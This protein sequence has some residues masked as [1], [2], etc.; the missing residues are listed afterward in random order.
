GI[1]VDA[2]AAFYRR[3]QQLPSMT[4]LH[5]VS[6]FYAW[7]GAHPGFNGYDVAG[8]WM[9]F[10]LD[11]QGAKKVR[12]YSRGVAAKEAFGKSVEDLEKLWHARL[13]AFVLRP[14]TELLLRQRAGE[15]V[16]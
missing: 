8:S 9:R 1:P 7:L 6:D 3:R 12:R 16:E 11:T 2:V 14:G 10:L 4:E 13:D 15:N 5:G